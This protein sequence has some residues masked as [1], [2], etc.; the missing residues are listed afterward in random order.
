M[1]RKEG[2][3]PES[4]WE[5]HVE[6]RERVEWCLK[7]EVRVRR[8]SFKHSPSHWDPLTFEAGG[9][10]IWQCAR[11]WLS[12][13]AFNGASLAD[14]HDHLFFPASFLLPFFPLHLFA[15]R[16]HPALAAVV[17]GRAG[18]D[19]RT[20]A[21]PAGV[22]KVRPEK[23]G[24]VC[25]FGTIPPDVWGQAEILPAG[26]ARRDSAIHDKGELDRLSASSRIR[27][28]AILGVFSLHGLLRS[29][30]PGSQ[31]TTG[32]E[33]SSCVSTVSGC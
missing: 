28:K 24:I 6:V 12:K 20:S 26:N 5:R 25:A 22:T 7:V 23:I 17:C 27:P 1:R 13:K 29:R 2:E 21:N 33:T 32:K 11:A 15:L 31:I 10:A 19:C 18:E 4:T 30:H 14:G 8:S 3:K 16:P 9:Y